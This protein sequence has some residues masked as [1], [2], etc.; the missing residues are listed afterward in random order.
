[1][2]LG[3]HYKVQGIIDIRKIYNSK[4]ILQKLRS[5]YIKK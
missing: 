1:M 5:V 3:F 4:W 2:E